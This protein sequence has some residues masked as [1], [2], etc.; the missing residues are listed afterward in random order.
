MSAL[1]DRHYSRQNAGHREFMGNGK[2]LVLR[3]QAGLVVFGWIYQPERNDGQKGY[4]CSIFRNEGPR[5]SSEIILEAEGIVVAKWGPNRVFTFINTHKVQSR[6][7][8]YCFKCA[9]WKSCGYSKNRGFLILEK[10]L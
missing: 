1:A 8:G 10:F 7:P 5:L 3:D 4:N 6:N 9:G 2:T